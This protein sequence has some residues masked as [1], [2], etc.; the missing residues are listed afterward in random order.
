LRRLKPTLFALKSDLRGIFLDGK[1]MCMDNFFTISVQL[2]SKTGPTWGDIF[3]VGIP[4]ITLLTTRNRT[5]ILQ[6]LERN[7]EIIIAAF[8]KAHMN[9]K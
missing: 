7:A 9:I 3:S 4:A 8:I 6:S 5:K 1:V 2:I